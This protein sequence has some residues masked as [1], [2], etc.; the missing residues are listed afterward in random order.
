MS[1]QRG[2]E[3]TPSTAEPMTG[4]SS[5]VRSLEAVGVEVVFGIPG[6]AILPLYDPLMDSRASGTSWSATSRAPATRPPGYAQAT[7][8]VGVCMATSGPGATNLVTPIADAYMDSVPHGGDH[9][10]GARS[11][12]IGTDAFQEAD[13]SGITHADHQAQL[14]GDRPGATSR[15]PSPRRSTSPHRPARPGA[16]RH[17]QG[18]AAGADDLHAGRTG[19]DL[20]GYRPVTRPHGKQVREAAR[21]LSDGPAAGALRR[22]RGDQGPRQHRAAPAGRADRGTGGHHPDG[23][24]RASRTP[25]RSTW[26]C[27]ACTA[28]WPRSPRCRRPTCSSPGRPVRRPGD[29]QAELASPRTPRSCTPTSTRPRSARTG[30][31]TCRSSVT[32][33]T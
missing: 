1:G 7:G 31:P 19:L 6:G 21:L 8:R 27:P 20:P 9:R 22:R 24:G 26:A 30:S 13:I 23:P 14:P 4:A 5:L 17:P 3:P 25:T 12:S 11:S 28:R 15:A 33:R 18:R 2:D 16:G 32:A 10:A 29:R